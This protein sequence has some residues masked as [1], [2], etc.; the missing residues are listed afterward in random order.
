MKLETTSRSWQMKLRL[1]N[2]PLI[3][4]VISLMDCVQAVY[5]GAL[6]VIALLPLLER[7]A[8]ERHTSVSLLSEIFLIITRSLVCSTLILSLALI[9][10]S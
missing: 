10:H 4:E 8:L 6:V 9:G 1:S 7:V 3:Q 5:L 2:N